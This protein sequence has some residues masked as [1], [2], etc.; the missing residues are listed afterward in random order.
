M[1]LCHVQHI[2]FHKPLHVSCQ[3]AMIFVAY[4]KL[5]AKEKLSRAIKLQETL[6]K[7]SCFPGYEQAKY[8]IHT[9]ACILLLNQHY[10]RSTM[11]ANTC[12]LT[13]ERIS[14]LIE[15]YE[16][17]PCLYKH[18]RTEYFNRDQQTKTMQE[19]ADILNVQGMYTLLYVSIVMTFSVRT[20][21]S[22]IL[23]YNN[24]TII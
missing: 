12:T 14:P 5:H 24:I 16:E 2:T 23:I 19:I 20:I 9:Y 10:Y 6:K 8:G 15:L 11:A 17:R 13:T 18:K 3:S 22:D 7:C 21:L 4:D 1:Q